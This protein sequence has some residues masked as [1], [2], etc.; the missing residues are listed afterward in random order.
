ML[1]FIYL[2]IF[3][4]HPGVVSVDCIRELQPD[5]VTFKEDRLIEGF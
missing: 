1:P 4:A 5:T 2:F 3:L